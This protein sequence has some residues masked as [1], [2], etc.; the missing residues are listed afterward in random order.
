MNLSDL[1][2]VCSHGRRSAHEPEKGE[3]HSP[4]AWCPGGRPVTL[5]DLEGLGE[6]V[7]WCP[8]HE[9]VFDGQEWT[10]M[11]PT[12]RRCYRFLEANKPCEITERILIAPQESLEVGE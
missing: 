9:G 12:L 10:G 3:I 11:D 6:K 4:T 8:V 2:I 5:A 1:F 7:W